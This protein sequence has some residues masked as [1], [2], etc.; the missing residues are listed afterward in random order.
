MD[1]A[2]I[3]R[4]VNIILQ[5]KDPYNHHSQ[6]VSSLLVAMLPY[7]DMTFTEAQIELVKWGGYLH[8]IGKVFLDDDLLNQPRRLTSIELQ[9][10][11]NHVEYGYDIAIFAGFDPVI[12]DII[13]SHHENMDGSGYPRGLKGEEIPLFARMARVADT[14]DALTSRRAYRNP[15]TTEEALMLL[16][17]EAGRIFDEQCVSAL[18]ECL[19]TQEKNYP[20]IL[21]LSEDEIRVRI[22]RARILPTS[23]IPRS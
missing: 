18:M 7:M 2:S 8:D 13:Q 16:K 19:S 6:N 22:E 11:R 9:H 10:L 4:V 3:V 23:P 20:E 5:R 1:Y 17:A 14:Y 15:S 12:C 21:K